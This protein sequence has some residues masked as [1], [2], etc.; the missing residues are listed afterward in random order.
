MTW[1]LAAAE[2]AQNSTPWERTIIALIPLALAVLALFSKRVRSKV[3]GDEQPKEP[4]PTSP[5]GTPRAPTTAQTVAQTMVEGAGLQHTL[6]VGLQ[7]Q[8]DD[9]RLS[10][11]RER[12][13]AKAELA[14]ERA[15][16]E[17]TDQQLDEARLEIANLRVVV[18]QLEAEITRWRTGWDRR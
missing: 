12:A 17:R 13:E 15:L 9:E 3:E 2:E 1:L 11:E 18:A 4:P 5:G 16:R 6:V 8:F 7:K 14:Q 10:R